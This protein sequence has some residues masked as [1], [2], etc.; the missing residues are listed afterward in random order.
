MFKISARRAPETTLAVQLHD[1]ILYI[2]RAS[3]YVMS[4]KLLPWLSPVLSP[5]LSKA[6]PREGEIIR[7][8]L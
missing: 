7:G 1:V 3:Q 4:N 8:V 6:E 2:S 5:W